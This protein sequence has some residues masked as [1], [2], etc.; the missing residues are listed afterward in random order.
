ML[1]SSSA[2]PV[3]SGFLPIFV[4]LIL[5][6]IW[7]RAIWRDLGLRRSGLA[8]WPVAITVPAG[9]AALV[10]AIALAG[11]LVERESLLSFSLVFGL[12]L[13]VAVTVVFVL[14]EEI[15]WRGFLLPR[16]NRST[17]PRRAAV[18]TGFLHAL[19]HLPLLVLT[20]TYNADGSR[21]LIAP[22]TIVTITAAGVLYAWLRVASGSIW[23]PTLAHAMG[24]TLVGMITANA[25]PGSKDLNA[26]LVGEGGLVSALV[27]VTVAVVILI[28]ARAWS[29]RSGRAQN[30]SDDGAT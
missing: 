18:V 1:P 25:T 3:A 2:A 7:G 5:S 11:G 13:N 10:Y 29:E 15:G 12:M 27:M 8:Y 4:L 6:M 21:W 19:V 22:V 24:N 23:P 30:D 28:R 20:T 26:H 16:I 17:S 9:V 14:S